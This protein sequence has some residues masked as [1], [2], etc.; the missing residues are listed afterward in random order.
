MKPIRLSKNAADYIRI[1]AHYLRQRSPAAAGKFAAAITEARR[2]LQTFPEAG[3]RTHGLQ[4]AGGLT[5]VVGDY[6]ID[7]LYDGDQ[8]DILTIRHGRMQVPSPDLSID[9]DLDL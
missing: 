3:N 1:E 5:L 8:V 7:Y 9:A 2:T 6:L 4:L